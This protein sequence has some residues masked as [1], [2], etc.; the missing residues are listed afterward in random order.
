MTVSELI[1]HLQRFDGNLEVSI[2]QYFELQ[3]HSSM[4][5][6][7]I[8]NGIVL[9]KDHYTRIGSR[10]IFTAY[11]GIDYDVPTVNERMASHET[12]RF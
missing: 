3:K 12:G 4:R 10:K 1:A 6:V 11:D 7:E 9:L 8:H 5:D 2:S